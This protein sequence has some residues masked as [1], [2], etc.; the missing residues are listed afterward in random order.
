MNEKLQYASMLEIPVSTCNVTFK[1][2]RKKLFK[3]NKKDNPEEVKAEL[4]EKVN[5]M[6]INEP[7]EQA[8]EY[9]PPVQTVTITEGG[10]K[11][12]Q[13]LKK[14]SFIALAVVGA[15]VALMVLT[16]AFYP[17][18]INAFMN[19]VFGAGKQVS[20][21]DERTFINFTP[22]ISFSGGDVS[23]DENGNLVFLGK[24]SVYAGC[25]GKVSSVSLMEDGKY[26]LEIAHSDNF[27]S[28]ISGLDFVYAN[29]G[30][31]VFG[32]IP[33]G[34]VSESVEMCF[35]GQDKNMIT[36]YQ[37]VDNTVVWDV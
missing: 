30:D 6:E 37:V 19:S 26:V 16:N 7:E 2:K 10:K 13:V 25:D 1:P 3:S 18:G 8:E 12:K 35:L 34:Y 27:S 24:G 32:N 20:V 21:T 17:S 15:L 31:A 29:I 36:D 22:C 5:A 11:R 9:T 28:V 23:A 33:V 14:P 4:L